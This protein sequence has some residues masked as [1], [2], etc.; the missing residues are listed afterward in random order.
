[1][2]GDVFDCLKLF[3][4]EKSKNDNKLKQAKLSPRESIKIGIGI[5]DNCEKEHVP[6]VWTKYLTENRKRW[7]DL[8]HSGRYS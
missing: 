7:Q 8:C 2:C 3:N 4:D 1:M 5:P 6:R